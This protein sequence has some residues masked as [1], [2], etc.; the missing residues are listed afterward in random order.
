MTKGSPDIDRWIRDDPDSLIDFIEGKDLD[1]N[2]F[3]ERLFKNLHPNVAEVMDDSRVRKLYDQHQIN[4]GEVPKIVTKKGLM[5]KLKGL[6]VMPKKIPEQIKV[7]S[8]KKGVRSYV[9]TRP[10]VFTPQEVRFIKARSKKPLKQLVAEY[11][12][13][14]S[15][16]RTASSIITKKYRL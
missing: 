2:N 8:G 1:F 12:K 15:Q 14:F 9:R 13:F 10:R 7:K 5:P 3:K 16:Q 4:V 6:K 11:N